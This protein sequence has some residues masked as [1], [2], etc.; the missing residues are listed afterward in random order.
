M[1]PKKKQNTSVQVEFALR[2]S[3]DQSLITTMETTFPQITLD[4]PPVMLLAPKAF[5]N[6]ILQNS[7][8]PGELK[9]PSLWVFLI[10]E[11]SFVDIDDNDLPACITVTESSK[12][13]VGS[14]DKTCA[15]FPLRFRFDNKRNKY[16]IAPLE[17]NTAMDIVMAHEMKRI[18]LGK[19]K[20]ATFDKFTA[21]VVKM[22]KA[23]QHQGISRALLN[24]LAIDICSFL[25]THHLRNQ[26][27]DE[28]TE[29]DSD[30]EGS[31]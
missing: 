28:D 30:V 5:L 22:V 8:V 11:K 26:D 12:Y 21:A 19:I 20:K 25:D 31:A 14:Y 6:C 4:I 18:M 9:D 15:G 17:T 1:P 24:E 29:D 7:N 3:S 2:D 23:Y 13:V 16:K 10:P 27:D